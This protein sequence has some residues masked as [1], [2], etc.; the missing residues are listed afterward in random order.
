MIPEK[1]KEVIKKS[2]KKDSVVCLSGAGISAESGI[3]TFRGKAGLWEKYDP[4]IYAYSEG[5]ISLLR[6]KPE[7]L[8]NFIVDFYSVLLR[9]RFNPAHAALSALEKK[10]IL[11]CVITQNIDDLHRLSGQRHI[12]ELHG[13]AFRAKCGGC[14]KETVLEKEDIGE[15]IQSLKKSRPSR[16]AL[17][18]ILS[19]YFPRCSCGS[20]FRIDIVL[21]GEMLPREAL[22]NALRSLDNCRLLLLIGTSLEVY[23]AASL[24]LYAKERGAILVEINSSP[25]ALSPICD[26][27]IQG[28]ACQVLPEILS[29]FEE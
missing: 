15:F 27:R 29:V 4:Q 8:A 22:S 13:N 16:T 12:I 21:F 20:R 14:C 2:C 9:A 10:G 5:L 17:L 7:E 11:R 19:Q 6:E 26:Y 28:S 23:P 3:P 25:G 1:L 24:P 18:K